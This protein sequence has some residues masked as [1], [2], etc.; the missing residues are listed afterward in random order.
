ML[1]RADTPYIFITSHLF[2]LHFQRSF[3]FASHYFF[4]YLVLNELQFSTGSS[5]FW[6][7]RSS[8]RWR[9]LCSAGSLG[10][11]WIKYQWMIDDVGNRSNYEQ[12]RTMT[13]GFGVLI[14]NSRVNYI[15]REYNWLEWIIREILGHL[16]LRNTIWKS[17]VT[18]K[19]N[20]RNRYKNDLKLQNCSIP[21]T[22]LCN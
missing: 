1:E 14:E 11:L 6:T 22:A 7:N 17:H 20:E 18:S 10:D 3:F 21:I 2:R 15:D 13:I 12:Q 16:L 5:I 19:D 9:N 4:F 8:F